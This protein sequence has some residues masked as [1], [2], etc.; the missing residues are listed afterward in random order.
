MSE[1]LQFSLLDMT[2]YDQQSWFNLVGDYNNSIWLSYPITLF[3]MLA[4]LSLIFRPAKKVSPHQSVRLVLALLAVSW[5]WCGAVFH[6]QYFS[7]LNWAAPWFGWVFVLQG[8]LLLLVAIFLK[9]ASWVSLSS[10]R[11]RLAIFLLII[12][13]FIYPLSGYLEGRVPIQ[14]ER[15]PVMP[16]PVILVSFA[17]IILLKSRWRHGLAVIPV[18]WGVV[19]AAFAIT[20]GLLE[21]Y[22]MA[23]AIVLWALHLVIR[24]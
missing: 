22:F 6:A 14:F 20:L 7:Q 18:L 11:G 9:A 12:G 3:V 1:L 15:F 21:F 19:S 13:L 24:V 8:G 16:A 2:P 10:L 23:G 17:L 4:M 5:L